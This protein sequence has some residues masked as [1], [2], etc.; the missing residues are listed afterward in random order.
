MSEV[1]KLIDVEHN[2]GFNRNSVSRGVVTC[3]NRAIS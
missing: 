1:I 3:I 2:L